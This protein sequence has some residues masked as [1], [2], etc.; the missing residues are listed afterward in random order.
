[1]KIC[2]KCNARY[3]YEMS[4][5]LTDGTPLVVG[6][7]NS[8]ATL[9]LPENELTTTEKTLV[10]PQ[11]TEVL[12]FKKT[13][14]TEIV[15]EKAVPVP[16]LTNEQKS[17]ALAAPPPSRLGL[18][19]GAL[20]GVLALLATAIGGFLYFNPFSKNN[21][22]ALANSNNSTGNQSI[23]LSNGNSSI[24]SNLSENSN[25]NSMSPSNINGKATPTTS[26]NSNKATPKPTNT[27]ETTPTPKPTAT[28]TPATPTPTPPPTPTPTR[29]P[30]KVVN[31]GV[32]N[33]KATNLVRPS[34]PP[35]AKAVRASGAVTVRVTID[36]NGNVISASAVNG[37]ALLRAS[38][39]SAARA[40]KFSPT[41]IGGQPVK[42]TGVIIYNFQAQ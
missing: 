21:E 34:Y 24:S 31:R 37:H 20:V 32:L 16:P 27:P 22:V 9:V 18:I 8:E 41:L 12:E 13:A 38:A 25:A 36:E 4:F 33:G 30:P 23:N 14:E 6:G 3:D 35:M 2:P 1:M 7:A 10:M 40:S 15:T 5:C 29:I 28:A 42:V 17:V 11:Q 39:E 19:I 26:P